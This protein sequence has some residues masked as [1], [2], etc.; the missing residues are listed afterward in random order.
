MRR[1]AAYIARGDF[2][3]AVKDLATALDYEPNNKE[4]AT[5]LEAIVA[6]TLAAFRSTELDT[7]SETEK[8]RRAWLQACVVRSVHGGWRRH[9]VKGNPSPGALNGHALFRGPDDRIYLFGGR[10]VR[11]NKANLFVRDD[12]D[13]SWDVVPTD[14]HTPHS[15]AWHSV[16]LIDAVRGILCVYG[17][18]SSLG[19]D[20]RVYLLLPD[21][22]SNTNGAT[23]ARVR[24]WRWVEA[25][26]DVDKGQVPDA[27]SGH[28]AVSVASRDRSDTSVYLFGGRTKRGVSS[29]LYELSLVTATDCDRDTVRWKLVETNHQNGVPAA[30]DGHSMCVVC[31]S[32]DQ[33]PRLIVFG[34]NGQQNDEKMN[35]TWA[36]D[37]A[38]RSWEV[39]ECSGDVP[40]PRSYHS[41][42]AIGQYMFVIG[43]RTVE[44]EDS[45]VYVLDTGEWLRLRLVRVGCRRH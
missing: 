27:R 30:R 37:V 22:T 29:S 3:L 35:D 9:E 44:T 16:S 31:A 15:R 32:D 14:G 42:H 38:T 17:G 33:P 10:S 45:S 13:C 11:D 8:Q 34:G 7:T 12:S 19:E 21:L 36:F 25:R 4:C 39:L 26:S 41:A 23:T 40:S 5:K 6:R 24:K 2:L 1:A 20:P 18:V 28:A 43:G